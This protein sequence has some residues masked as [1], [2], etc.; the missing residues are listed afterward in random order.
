MDQ[1]LDTIL[2]DTYTLTQ[3]RHRIRVLREYVNSA[4]FISPPPKSL[5]DQDDLL[6][7]NSLGD[8]FYKQ[9]NKNN[10]SDVLS[11]LEEQIQKITPLIIYI[12]FIADNLAI[13]EIAQYARN[14][15]SPALLIEIKFDPNLIA[16]AA[17][18]FKG[19]YKDYSLRTKIQD[20]KGEILQG[21]RKFLR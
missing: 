5:I 21:F 20:K 16:G 9:F 6:W 8:D 4:L 3:L 12:P 2:K 11:K 17:L 7:L 14:L 19:V 15:I 13:S 18:S 10:V 1:I